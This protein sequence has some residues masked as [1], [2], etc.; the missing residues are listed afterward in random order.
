MSRTSSIART[1][2]LLLA[3]LLPLPAASQTA[4]ANWD[5]AGWTTSAT[6]YAYLPSIGGTTRFPADSSGPTIDVST[7]KILDSLNFAFM[8]TVDVNNGRFGV[9]TDVMYLDVSG[10]HSGTRDFSIGSGGLPADTSANLD[11]GI[12]AWVWTLAG[13][14][15]LVSSPEWRVDGLLGARLLDV[16]ESLGWSIAGSL[17]P[18]SAGGRTGSVTLSQ[19]NWDAVAGVKGRYAF[20]QDHAWA[21][22]FYADVGTGQSKLTWQAAAGIA[23]AFRWGD[24]IAMWRYVEYKFK[25]G[26]QIEDLNLNGPMIG[27]TFRW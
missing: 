26:N 7:D 12:R 3:P 25:S 24:V 23:Y 9:F 13:E 17:G 18:I 16:R 11:V 20:G 27:V 15:R 22:P 4:G 6:L 10:N 5:A 2:L 8:G 19:N 21:L 14:Y 1:S